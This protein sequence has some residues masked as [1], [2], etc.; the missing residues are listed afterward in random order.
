MAHAILSS[1]DARGACGRLLPLQNR[2]NPIGQRP[3]RFGNDAIQFALLKFDDAL[4]LFG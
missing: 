2:G 4:I 1:P 3:A